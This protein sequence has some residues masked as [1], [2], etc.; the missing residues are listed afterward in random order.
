MVMAQGF[1]AT[2]HMGMLHTARA[3]CERVGCAALTFDHAGFGESGGGERNL[4]RWSMAVSYLDAVSYLFEVESATV[5]TSRICVWGESMSSRYCLVACA[6]EPRIHSAIL[7]TPPCGRAVSARGE[8][9][10]PEDVREMVLRVTGNVEGFQMM[11]DQLMRMRT[12]AIRPDDHSL[13]D[14]GGAKIPDIATVQPVRIIPRELVVNEDSRVDLQAHITSLMNAKHHESLHVAASDDES[15]DED[16]A[17]KRSTE[18]RVKPRKSIVCAGASSGSGSASA[19]SPLQRA[20]RKA[21]REM[22]GLEPKVVESRSKVW[23]RED[24]RC[25]YVDVLVDFCNQYSLLPGANWTNEV[26]YVE[27][28]GL[29]PW[30]DMA[31]VPQ[32]HSRLLFLVAEHDEM[33]NCN[34]WVQYET[35]QAATSA[36]HKAFVEV[37]TA[38]GGHAGMM[39]SCGIIGRHDDWKA[40]V[41]EMAKF[42]NEVWPV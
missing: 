7:V 18:P 36:P 11:R 10:S 32:I 29:P 37:P 3:T 4:C 41:H 19:T 14:R 12:R 28:K 27:R 23:L 16:R 17:S 31:A 8:Q 6:V 5:D 33:E 30:A 20:L 26:V 13:G 35:F 9:L 40:M 38:I 34:K 22:H 15:D 42:L 2:Q 21:S 1:G 39:D 24:N 25:K